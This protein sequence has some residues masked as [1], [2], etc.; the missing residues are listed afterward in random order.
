[1]RLTLPVLSLFVLLLTGETLARPSFPQRKAHNATLSA[2][3]AK[4]QTNRNEIQLRAHV[5]DTVKRVHKQIHAEREE[6]VAEAV[7]S[8][9]VEESPSRVR[10]VARQEPSAA[11]KRAL[12]PTKRY[13]APRQEPSAAR[14]RALPATKRHVAPRQEPSAARK[15]ALPAPARERA[16]RALEARREEEEREELDVR[17]SYPKCKKTSARTGYAHYPGWKLVGD[18]VS[19]QS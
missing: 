6:A 7:T 15:R 3:I 2:M 4:R 12:P 8:E 19:F 1:M 13:L 5:K 11:R 14:K 16:A 17:S 10:N 18:E 9:V